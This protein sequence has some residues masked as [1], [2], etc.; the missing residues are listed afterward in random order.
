MKVTA[1]VG[2]ARKKHTYTAAKRLLE[3]L[4]SLGDVEYEIVGLSD[5][6]LKTC[7][8]CKRCCDIGEEFCPLNDDRDKLIKKMN[9][10]LLEH[11]K[12][13]QQAD[14]LLSKYI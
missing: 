3:N 2:S 5:Y 6:N 7:R 8:G 11:Q 4:K 14:K 12:K 9:E 13:I 1:F 10:F